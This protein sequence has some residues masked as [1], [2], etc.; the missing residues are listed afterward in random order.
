MDEGLE[1]TNWPHWIWSGNRLCLL[2]KAKDVIVE[3]STRGH[4]LECI[5]DELK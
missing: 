5:D 4:G 2:R 1:Y 3:R